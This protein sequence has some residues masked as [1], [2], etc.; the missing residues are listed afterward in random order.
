MSGERDGDREAM[1]RVTQRFIDGGMDPREAERRARESMRRVDRM[2]R[3]Q[4][5]R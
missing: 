5:K 4:G 3:E 2:Q 1:A